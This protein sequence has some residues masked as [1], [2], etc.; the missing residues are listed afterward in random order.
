M[1]KHYLIV[2]IRN[3]RRY[4]VYSVIN[5]L[6][7]AIALAF[8]ILVV[9]FVK[10]EWSYNRFHEKADR[11]YRVIRTE[12]HEDNKSTLSFMPP[13]LAQTLMDEIPEIV[14]VARF[15]DG[16]TGIV[17]YGDK[18][19]SEDILFGNASVFR[20]FTFPFSRGH[21]AAALEDRHSA[22]MTEKM[23]Q[24][25]FG[26]EDPVGKRITIR[27]YQWREIAQEFV[28]AGVVETI[29]SNSSIRFDFL[30]PLE[31]IP[32]SGAVSQS[33]SFRSLSERLFVELSES[34]RI[35]DLKE[36]LTL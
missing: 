23:A 5:L 17:Q 29:P 8:S 6:G 14:D 33:I 21:A 10:H 28:I 26:N 15:Q 24:K 3:L 7:L 22:V 32:V 25:Y 1:L 19:F 4:G 9:L 18:V 30:L 16:F 2:A 12:M 11:I 27:H 36:K 35:P 20:V 34:A 31:S 13:N